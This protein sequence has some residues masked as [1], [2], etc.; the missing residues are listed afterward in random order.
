MNLELAMV[1]LRNDTNARRSL[2]NA[3]GRTVNL[4]PDEKRSILMP[5]AQAEYLQA[6][7]QGSLTVLAIKRS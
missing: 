1:S 4:E 7:A 3:A 2:T 6:S 5:L